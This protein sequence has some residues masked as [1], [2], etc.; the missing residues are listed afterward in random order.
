MQVREPKLLSPEVQAAICNE[1]CCSYS[2]KIDNILINIACI[3]TASALQ[4]LTKSPE[5]VARSVLAK[6]MNRIHGSMTM[7]A[8]YVSHL[9]LGHG[10]SY[11]SY[12]TQIVNFIAYVRHFR[13][14]H[15]QRLFPDASSG[16]LIQRLAIDSEG[17]TGFVNEVLTFIK[18]DPALYRLSPMEMAIC[19][20]VAPHPKKKNTP[21][22]LQEGHPMTATHG[23]R[24]KTRFVLPQ[25]L[26]DPPPRPA[27]TAPVEDRED[28]AAYALSVFYSDKYMDRLQGATLWDKLL[29]WED[30]TRRNKGPRG[31]DLDTFALRM[32]T[33]VDNMAA[34]RL[35]SRKDRST[36]KSTRAAARAAARAQEV[37]S[38]FSDCAYH[39]WSMIISLTIS[40][41]PP[42]S[43]LQTTIK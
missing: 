21:F 9:L 4:D 16:Q 8:I 32:L 10:D 18:R 24:P 30:L 12:K 19:I 3:I 42:I 31:A 28:Y 39:Y 1:Y 38:V 27:D 29:S 15:A 14:S 37:R 7:G 23:L 2:F 17:T 41:I 36:L 26:H 22:L 34:A 11:I 6:A 5:Q 13:P 20:Q 25:F 43:G 35:V 40:I 33:N